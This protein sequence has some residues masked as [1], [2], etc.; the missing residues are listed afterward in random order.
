[1]VHHTEPAARR[2]D[3]DQ[4][5]TAEDWQ[6]MLGELQKCRKGERWGAFAWRAI[7]L[8]ILFPDRKGELGL[9]DVAWEAM[10]SELRRHREQPDWASFAWQASRLAILFPDWKD[11]LG[12]EEADWDGMLG[13]LRRHREHAVWASFA[14]Q[15]SDLAILSADEV[16]ISKERGFELVNHPRVESTQPLP[17]RQ[18][19]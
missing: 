9:D 14:E 6:R 17:P 2:F 5:I 16:R 12:L 3:V 8:T 7:D 13:Q 1:L 10:L 15:A 4:D 19:V 18:A 11:E